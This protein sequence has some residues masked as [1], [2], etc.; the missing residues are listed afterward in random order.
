MAV[1]SCVREREFGQAS[2]SYKY[3]GESVTE[4]FR[5]DMDAQSLDWPTIL[6]Q[7]QALGGGNTPPPAR[8]AAWPANPTY[9]LYAKEYQFRVDP[10]R[11]TRCYLD[12][13]YLP[14]ESGESNPSQS[15]TNPLLWPAEYDIQYIEEEFVIEEARNV[16][17]F[18]GT[19]HTRAA[20]TLGPV[21]NSA[22]DE[23]EE[24]LVDTERVAVV[25]IVK[26]VAS[27]NSIVSQ[28]INFARTTNSDTFLGASARRAKFIGAESGGR[29]VANGIEYFPMITSV[30]IYKTTD[31]ILNNVGW[32]NI[33]F[34]GDKVKYMVTD[35]E[36][37][38]LIE[39]S[40]P[41]FLTLAGGRST[42][43]V[44]ITYRYLDA[45]SYA[46]LL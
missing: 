13:Q 32:N 36:T 15:T 41:G 22:L 26:N 45:V 4:R 3:G 46:G 18:T 34:G 40:A 35:D 30:A 10:Q 29:Q 14:V 6:S 17:A 1:T 27:L 8:G 42:S 44:K 23:T 2:L 28:N 9:G 37:D 39:P 12:V 11:V 7:A 33:N 19:N 25:K 38:E 5:I 21:V 24:P 20:N 31:R 16:E 43:P